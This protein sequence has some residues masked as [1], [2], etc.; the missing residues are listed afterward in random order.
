[1]FVNSSRKFECL[2]TLLSIDELFQT[3]DV[4]R[5]PVKQTN[6]SKKPFN[7]R[8]LLFVAFEA[9]LAIGVWSKH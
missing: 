4:V 9:F 3:E 2:V 7:E 6:K 5:Q 8:I 1:M